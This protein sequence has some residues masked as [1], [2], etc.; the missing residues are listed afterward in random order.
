MTPTLDHGMRPGVVSSGP[1]PCEPFGGGSSPVSD[2]TRT[3]MLPSPASGWR[4][5]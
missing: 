1:G 2:V 5:K 3:V 4:T